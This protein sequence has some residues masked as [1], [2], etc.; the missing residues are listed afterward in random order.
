MKITKQMRIEELESMVSA[1]TATNQKLILNLNEIVEAGGFDL[2]VRPGDI[3]KNTV[4]RILQ[5]RRYKSDH[6]ASTNVEL[7]SVHRENSRLWYLVRSMVKDETLKGEAANFV[8]QTRMKTTP[9]DNPT[10]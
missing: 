3:H 2:K 8:D 4:D 5:L 6:E 9:F 1:L 7:A 10:F